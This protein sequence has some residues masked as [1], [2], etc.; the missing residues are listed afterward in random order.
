MDCGY[1]ESG[2]SVEG[3]GAFAGAAPAD[4][5]PFAWED[6]S[7]DELSGFASG[8]VFDCECFFGGIFGAWDGD[9]FSGEYGASGPCFG[10]GAG[11][12]SGVGGFGIGGIVLVGGVI[13]V[14]IF[15]GVWVGLVVGVGGGWIGGIVGVCGGV[16][17]GVCVG[18]VFGGIF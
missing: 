13:G 3:P 9:Q 18:V 12:M 10:A 4:E 5:E 14:G 17:V 1:G 2:S 11:D 16:C 15:G 6:D 8:G 7:C